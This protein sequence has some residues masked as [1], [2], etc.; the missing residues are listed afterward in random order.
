MKTRQSVLVILVVLLA[1][2]W[3]MAKDKNHFVFTSFDPPGSVLTFPIGINNNG[4]IAGQYND[5]AGVIHTF[6]LK[7]GNYTVIDVPG[8]AGT[9]ASAPNNRGQVALGYFNAPDYYTHAAVYSRGRYIYLP[10][11]PGQLNTSPS[12]INDRGYISGVVWSDN[13]TIVHSYVWDGKTCDVYDEPA[14]DIHFTNAFAINNRGQIVGQYNTSD[15]V[16][17][18]YLKYRDNYTEITFPGA[19]NT[20][21]LGINNADVIV[22]LYGNA[23]P[24]PYGFAVGSHGYVMWGGVYSTLDYPGA[25]S[26]FSTGINDVGQIVGV[27]HLNYA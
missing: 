22:G 10:D 4:L 25:V 15:G 16:I 14:S 11:C 6:T 27:Y 3:A 21:A 2:G 9:L 17:H 5:A 24:G 20:V 18:G 8:A 7:G 23:G 26:S 12:A 1:Q 13:F 19:P